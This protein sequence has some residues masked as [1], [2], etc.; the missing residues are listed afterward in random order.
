MR[1]LATAL[2]ALSPRGRALLAAILVVVLAGA[3]FL[4]YL[5]WGGSPFGSG[6]RVE[7]LTTSSGATVSDG[8]LVPAG[9]ALRL[10][11]NAEMDE[12]SLRLLANGTPLGLSWAQDRRSAALDVASL[13]RGRVALSVAPGARDTAGHSLA[14]WELAFSLIFGLPTHTVPL[15]APVLVQVPN[16][17]SARDQAGLQAAAFVYEYVTEGGVTRFTAIYT[18]AP[19]SVGPVRSGRLISFSLTRHYRGLLLASGLSEGSAA[20][21]RSNPVPHVF[22]TGG[23]VFQRRGDRSSPNNLF[24]GGTAMQRAVAGA[25]LPHVVLPL[26]TVPIHSGAGATSVSVP[27]HRS[28]YSFATSTGTYTKQ[29]EGRT[30]ADAGTGQPLHIQLLVVLHTT[31]TQTSFVEDVNGA[32]GLDFDMQSG[33][34]AEFYFDGIQAN[35]RWTTPSPNAPLRFQLDSGTTVSPPPLTWVDVVTS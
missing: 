21:L 17:P 28:V 11:F 3:G 15:S 19:D 1:R 10:T 35:G 13:H 31:A 22:D 5:V 2:R 33:G 12:S 20:V 30:L 9:T 24:T 25:S 18:S 7:A 29:V 6:P 16:D 4:G 8:D 23:G 27:Q 32:H 26:G 34:R 14:R